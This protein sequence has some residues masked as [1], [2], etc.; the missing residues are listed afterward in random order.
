MISSKKIKKGQIENFI[1][2]ATQTTL[3]LK[4][5]NDVADYTTA[6]TP[7]AG[8]EIALVEQG[9][10]FK[11]VAVSE[12]GGGSSD[13]LFDYVNPNGVYITGITTEIEHV[14]F[15][16]PANTLNSYD[17]LSFP[18]II[19]E[20]LP[21]SDTQTYFFI[22]ISTDGVFS[23]SLPF[24]F[25][26]NYGA[27]ASRAVYKMRRSFT[28]INNILIGCVN[29][30]FSSNDDS[31]QT[32]TETAID[33]SQDFWIHISSITNNATNQIRLNKLKITK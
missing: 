24:I 25:R 29:T 7:L 3:D 33:T 21:I 10:T 17:G 18:E 16:I 31:R 20:A 13:L 30:S 4:L 8:T 11:K 23:S 12:F 1:S 32:I 15:K 9:G 6:T 5:S 14:N 26:N 22:R 2:D 28:I 19:F 27:F